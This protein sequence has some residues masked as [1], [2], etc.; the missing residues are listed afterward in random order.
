MP[1]ANP[2][3]RVCEQIEA[4][5]VDG[6]SE[7]ALYTL[8]LIAACHPSLERELDI[9]PLAERYVH[10][11][12]PIVLA[13]LSH[14]S[15]QPQGAAQENPIDSPPSSSAAT[16]KLTIATSVGKLRDTFEGMNRIHS[17]AVFSWRSTQSRLTDFFT[18]TRVERR[19][20]K[21]AFE[22]LPWGR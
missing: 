9:L 16:P 5:G 3:E 18:R 19:N 10:R 22:Q 7:R 12:A 13:H 20:L 6:T 17:K 11:T 14:R 2:N 21:S 4:D 1:Q 15:S 8:C